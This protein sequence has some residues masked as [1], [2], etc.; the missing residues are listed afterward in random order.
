MVYNMNRDDKEMTKS[1][2]PLIEA[3]KKYCEKAK[4]RGHTPGHRGGKNLSKQLI[5]MDVFNWDVTEVDGLGNLF[6]E[7]G[8]IYESELITSRIYNSVRTLFFTQ[9]STSAIQTV[10]LALSKSKNK[11]LVPRNAHL[12]VLNS[13]IISGLIPTWYNAKVNQQ[14]LFEPI[15]ASYVVNLIEKYPDVKILFVQN[16]TYEGNS[17]D[18]REIA[19]ICKEN[20][21]IL[22]VDEAH[23][24]HWILSDA[25]PTS[26]TE[27]NA[28]FV[29]QSPHKTLP[30]LTGAAY[31]HINDTDYIGECLLARKIVHSTSPSYLI[32]ASLDSLNSYNLTQGSFDYLELQK[33]CKEFNEKIRPLKNISTINDG[34]I[35]DFTKITLFFNANMGKVA[36]IFEKHGIIIEKWSGNTALLLFTPGI[37]QLEF[38][39]IMEALLEVEKLDFYKAKQNTKVYDFNLK[40]VVSVRDAFFS[41]HEFVRVDEAIGR[42]SAST[43]SLIPPGIPLLMPG[44]LISF[45]I[46]KSIKELG[47]KNNLS[48]LHEANNELI[49]V[50][51][52]KI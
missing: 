40:Q 41:Q 50:V 43:V 46:V 6:I 45:D 44:E 48:G 13:I 31:L 11:I 15:S 16:P 4:F 26:A 21:V 27:V 29:I 33:I 22:I 39:C 18:I 49:A 25:L 5:D 38:E 17:C 30:A 32:L 19:R 10:F 7:D 24:A 1:V 51:K 23:G 36:N 12:S 28:D 42:I 9:G 14:G 47:M 35:K 34:L 37:I 2:V 3:I 20:D 8:P 52:H